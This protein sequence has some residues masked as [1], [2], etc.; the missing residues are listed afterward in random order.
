[1]DYAASATS[2]LSHQQLVIKRC[3]PCP[4]VH[5]ED[6]TIYMKRW[7]Q[8]SEILVQSGHRTDSVYAPNKT[9]YP[10]QKPVVRKGAHQQQVQPSRPPRMAA[11][12]EPGPGASR[13]HHHARGDVLACRLKHGRIP[14]LAVS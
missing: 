14:K 2:P 7:P 9:R 11:E 10:A 1:M 3:H 13:L 12:R 6:T 4:I 8:V 5:N